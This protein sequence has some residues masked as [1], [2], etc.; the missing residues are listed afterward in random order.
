MPRNGHVEVTA[1][2]DKQRVVVRVIDDGP[3]IPPDVQSRMF[4]LFF[5]TKPVGKGTGIGLDLVR[6]L[7]IHNNATIEVD[8]IP[9][10][11]EFRVLLPSADDVG[12]RP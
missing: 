3:G 8:S 5:T 4:D 10:R 7:L 1:T 2:R 12:G 9:G 6:R 11:T